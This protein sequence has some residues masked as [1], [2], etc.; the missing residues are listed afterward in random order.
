[1][2]ILGI[3]NVTFK[4]KSKVSRRY[5]APVCSVTT[6]SDELLM[7]AGKYLT[8]IVRITAS[9]T[10]TCICN[11]SCPS[12]ERPRSAAVIAHTCRNLQCTNNFSWWSKEPCGISWAHFRANRPLML[13]RAFNVCNNVCLMFSGPG[14]RSQVRP[15]LVWLPDVYPLKPWGAFRHSIYLIYK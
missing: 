3:S 7:T 6:P 8:V 15:A 9:G 12:Q 4:L 5:S 1:M 13:G 11:V 14:G 10:H 2:N